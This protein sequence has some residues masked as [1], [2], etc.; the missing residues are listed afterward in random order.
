M[1]LFLTYYYCYSWISIYKYNYKLHF[2]LITDFKKVR[3]KNQWEDRIRVAMRHVKVNN[4][5]AILTFWNQLW[6][7]L[8]HSLAMPV[9]NQITISLISMD[10]T[11]ASISSTITA[12]MLRVF[13]ITCLILPTPWPFTKSRL[14]RV[15]PTLARLVTLLGMRFASAVLLVNLISTCNVHLVRVRYLLTNTHINWG[16]ISAPHMKIRIWNM[17][18]IS[19]TK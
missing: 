6:I 18:V 11:V 12:S 10:A 1:A 16:S 5:L 4:T 7:V 3:K 8:K 2:L 9:S 17:F 19:A 13:S 15:V 14:T